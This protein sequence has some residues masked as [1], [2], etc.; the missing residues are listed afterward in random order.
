ML[1]KPFSSILVFWGTFLIISSISIRSY[2]EDPEVYRKEIERIKDALSEYPDN[3]HLLWN[4]AR[5]Y[6]HVGNEAGDKKQ[7]LRNYKMCQKYVRKAISLSDK[8]AES[9]FWLGICYGKEASIRGMFRGLALS[10]KIKSEMKRVV[11]LDPAYSH[12]GGHR[13]LGRLFFKM[14]ALFGGNMKKARSHLE[15]AV[16]IAP[17][18]STNRLFL[19]EVYL[20]K[21]K[22]YLAYKEL[23]ILQNLPYEA[24][25]EKSVKEEREKAKKLMEGIPAEI[26]QKFDAAMV[27]PTDPDQSKLPMEDR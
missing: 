3:V 26:K 16:R 14:P 22:Y 18:Y 25:R 27:V 19:T 6:Y 24:E 13:T 20:R 17:D 21:K 1:E 12:A 2:G 5:N 11:E 10:D 9:H 4:V 7:K 23:R 15:E 8:S